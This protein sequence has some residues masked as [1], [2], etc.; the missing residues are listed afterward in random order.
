MPL[1]SENI[2][3]MKET[4]SLIFKL[5]SLTAP[6]SQSVQYFQGNNGKLLTKINAHNSSIDFFSFGTRKLQTRV[7]LY[8][9]GPNGLGNID[10]LS[11][12]IINLDSVLILNPWTSTFFIINSKGKVIFKKKIIIDDS[13]GVGEEPMGGTL[14]PIYFSS[15]KIYSICGLLG[16][17]MDDHTK[18]KCVLIHDLKSGVTKKVLSRPEVYNKG[19]W[20]TNCMMD[21]CY[22]TFNEHR[23][24]F[25]YSFPVDN[26]IYETSHTDVLR[27]HLASSALFTEVPPMTTNR[28]KSQEHKKSVEY[29]YTTS[30]YFNIVY[31]K[32]RK[33]Y[34]RFTLLSNTTDEILNPSIQYQQNQSVIIL[35][36]SFEKLGE[37][38]L[39]ARKY[40]YTDFFINEDGLFFLLKPSSTK[41]ED[42]MIYLKFQPKRI[43]K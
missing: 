5:D 35:N 39:P 14:Q 29:D 19:N 22:V 17:S 3:E 38:V 6:T 1:N 4:G 9:E 37:S 18:M 36:E 23:K 26:Y 7:P 16:L 43:D 10:Y 34:Y 24:K 8:K 42:E 32:Y 30:H 41:N 33:L 28:L 15:N 11:H 27:K 40:N 20:G 13:Q 2:L 21:F 12:H 31:D 25:I